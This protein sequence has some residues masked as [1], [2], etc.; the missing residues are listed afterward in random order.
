[1]VQ[2]R[3]YTKSISIINYTEKSGLFIKYAMK[4]GTC[5]VTTSFR[6]RSF[7]S[8]KKLTTPELSINLGYFQKQILDNARIRGFIRSW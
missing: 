1:M 4:S 6:P 5:F 3:I 8:N 7:Q 2:I